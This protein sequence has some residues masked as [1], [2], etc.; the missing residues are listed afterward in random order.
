MLCWV[1]SGKSALNIYSAHSSSVVILLPNCDSN[2]SPSTFTL[3]RW[4]IS[5]I[6][7]FSKQSIISSSNSC[8]SFC[9]VIILILH[10]IQFNDNSRN[11]SW[12]QLYVSHSLNLFM[13]IQ[14]SVRKSWTEANLCC[15]LASLSYAWCSL[16]RLQSLTF[17][18]VAKDTWDCLYQLQSWWVMGAI[19][20]KCGPD[21]SWVLTSYSANIQYTA[22]AVM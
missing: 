16:H 8:K 6:L 14:F 4:W 10:M 9:T 21:S 19:W 3:G 7:Y 5:L 20:G 17:S 1:T 11:L 13:L 22:L 12:I 18:W 15:F 2:N